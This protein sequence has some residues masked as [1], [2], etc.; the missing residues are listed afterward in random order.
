MSALVRAEILKLVRRRGLMI[1]SLILTVGVTLLLAIIIIALHAANPDHHGPAGGVDGFEG[2]TGILG[3]LGSV[4]AIIIGSTAGTQDVQ[5]G[6]FRDLAVT[7]RKRSTLFNVRTPGAFVVLLMM[8]VPAFLLALLITFAF[9]GSKPTPSGGEIAHV[10]LY[11]FFITTINLVLAIGL[12]AYLS[13]R[14]VV[15]V[16]IAWYAI[17]SHILISIK[18]LGGA[19]NLIDTAAA[20]RFA[21]RHM[22]DNHL[23][24]SYATAVV[25]L[26]V[27]AA[28]FLA[29]GGFWTTRRDA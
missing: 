1:W 19:R 23:S 5:N 27:W 15:G 20:E 11:L 24:M 18:A 21:P 28:V 22:I 17:A 13:S 3:L 10:V 25:V 26:L 29:A 4:V 9:P 7:G 2:Y 14:I 8:I 12:A 16:A 6:V